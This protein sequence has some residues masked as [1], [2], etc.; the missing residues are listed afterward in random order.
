MLFACIIN[1]I[2]AIVLPSLRMSPLLIAR[3]VTIVLFYATVLS[4]SVV[5]IQSIGSGISIFG[6]LLNSFLSLQY[7]NVGE[8]KISPGMDINMFGLMLSSL[9][10]VKPAGVLTRRRLTDLE[11]E[12][13]VLTDELKQILVGIILGDGY[14]QKQGFNTRFKFEQGTV[15]EEY[16]MHLYDLFSIYSGKAPIIKHRPPNTR[17]SL[18]IVACNGPREKGYPLFCFYYIKTEQERGVK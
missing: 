12:K 16:L 8:T 18:A 11:K 1:N 13:I 6:D 7:C 4:L 15:H 2:L 5:Y 3:I 9:L 10:V 17:F 14:G